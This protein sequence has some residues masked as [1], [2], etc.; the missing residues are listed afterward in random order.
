MGRLEASRRRCM[1]ALIATLIG[2]CVAGPP[3]APIAPTPIC[4]S[5]QQCAVMWSTARTFV[6]DHAQMRIQTYS[7]DFLETYN[8]I[9]TGIA[10]RVNMAPAQGG[11]YRIEAVFWCDNI[12]GCRTPPRTLLDEFNKTVAAAAQ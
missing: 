5:E 12:F 4:A 3:P 10:A 7:A 2:G 9:D 1:G 11:G 8:P 6:L